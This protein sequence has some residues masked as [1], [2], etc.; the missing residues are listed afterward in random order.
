M[1]KLFTIAL[2]AFQETFRRRVFYIV[3]LLAILVAIAISSEFFY[4]QMARDAGETETVLRAGRAFTQMVIGIWNFAAFFLALFLGA[5]GLSSEISNKTI[6]HVLSRPVPRWIYLLGRWLGLLVFLWLFLLLGIVAALGIA[7]WFKVSYAPT[8]W[9]AFAEM[10]VKAAFFSG[11]ALS[12]S[13]ITPPVLAGAIT[14]ILSILPGVLSHAIVDPHWFYRIPALIGYYLGPA[15][16]PV[17]LV[18][19]SFAKERLHADYFLYGRVLTEN[20]VYAI[21]A[22]ILAALLFRRKELR[23]R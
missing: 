13:V 14:F 8:L 11:V 21:A 12:F 2:T 4:V 20:L 17:D 10:F 6:V 23:L 22:L 15:N 7:L 18:D 5:I 19:E 9:L 1:A 3:L 16:M